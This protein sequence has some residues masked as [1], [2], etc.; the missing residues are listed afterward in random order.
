LADAL[1]GRGHQIG[2]L[3]HSDNKNTLS[4]PHRPTYYVPVLKSKI[5]PNDSRLAQLIRI[6]KRE[7][8]DVVILYNVFNLWAVAVLRRLAPT[9]RYFHSHE[10]YWVGLSKTLGELGGECSIPHSY[11]RIRKCRQDL[12]FPLRVILYL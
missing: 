4:F 8:P 10:M 11:A 7:R 6:M 12:W 2:F 5:W 1:E 3:Y 9:I